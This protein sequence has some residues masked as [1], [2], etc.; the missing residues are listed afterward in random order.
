MMFGGGRGGDEDDDED[1]NEI[2]DGLFLKLRFEGTSKIV[3]KWSRN[4]IHLFTIT[5]NLLTNYFWAFKFQ[6]L[7]LLFGW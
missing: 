4:R 5:I 3:I 2:E 6:F 7:V 1:G